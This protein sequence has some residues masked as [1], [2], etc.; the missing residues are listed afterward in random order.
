MYLFV[1]TEIELTSLLQGHK[2]VNDV[3]FEKVLNKVV[4]LVSHFSRTIMQ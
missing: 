3:I 2:D 1:R 4:K